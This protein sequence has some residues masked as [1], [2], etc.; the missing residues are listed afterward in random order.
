[1]GYEHAMDAGDL[2]V[3]EPTAVEVDGEKLC[4]V[5]LGDDEVVAF[6]DSCPH[7]G[8]P[9]SAGRLDGTVVTCATHSWRFDVCTGGMVG[10]RAPH[11]LQLRAARQRDGVV[12]VDPRRPLEPDGDDESP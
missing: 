7:Q 4:L 12:E 5:R 1:M 6:V 10:L 9:L 3:G 2:P 8:T 11:R